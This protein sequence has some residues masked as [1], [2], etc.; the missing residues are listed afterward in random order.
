MKKKWIWIIIAV[1]VAASGAVAA[2]CVDWG[3]AEPLSKWGIGKHIPKAYSVDGQEL[4]SYVRSSDTSVYANI[5][6]DSYAEYLEY[7]R[8][9]KSWGFSKDIN[10][11]EQHYWAINDNGYQI[12][13]SNLTQYGNIQVLARPSGD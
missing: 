13:V 3:G 9:V 7:I 5:F 4:S 12:K 8:L 10:E 2:F 11:T 1:A 6:S